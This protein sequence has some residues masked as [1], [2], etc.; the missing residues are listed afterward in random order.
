MKGKKK[1]TLDRGVGPSGSIL[2]WIYEV[3]V[4]E[5]AWSA[6]EQQ[7]SMRRR[8][9]ASINSISFLDHGIDPVH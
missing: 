8:T 9:N 3:I 2:K 6:V 7:I 5:S 1:R 4:I